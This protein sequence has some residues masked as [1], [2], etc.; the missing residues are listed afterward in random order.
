MT[1]YAIALGTA[2]AL[3]AA[4]LPA[5]TRAAPD[6]HQLAAPFSPNA[7]IYRPECWIRED[8]SSICDAAMAFS[9]DNLLSRM[10]Q[11]WTSDRP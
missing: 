2:L 9:G 4:V 5:E 3:A 7:T 6:S 8:P 11:G 1:K 10:I